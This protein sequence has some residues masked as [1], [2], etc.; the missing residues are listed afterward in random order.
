[1]K[2]EVQIRSIL[3]HSWAEIEHDLGYKNLEG[4]PYHIKRKFSR[5]ASLLEVA[6]LEFSNIRSEIERYSNEVKHSIIE[7]NLD[8][9]LDKVSLIEFLQKVNIVRD[10][11]LYWMTKLERKSLVLDVGHLDFFLKILKY[12]DIHTISQ[13]NDSFNEKEKEILRFLDVYLVK[14][15]LEIGKDFRLPMG[16]S[17]LFFGFFLIGKESS[18]EIERF[19]NYLFVGEEQKNIER[20]ISKVTKAHEIF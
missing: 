6:D 15:E 1:M 3:Q 2:F 14:N 8:V 7:D 12:L 10:I 20:I 18:E 17:I 11:D 16:S 5:V 13:L 19:I 9:L 4:I